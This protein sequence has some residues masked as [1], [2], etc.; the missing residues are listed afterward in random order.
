[1]KTENRGGSG[2]TTNDPVGALKDTKD[3]APLD[4]FKLSHILDLSYFYEES[5]KEKGEILKGAQY[6]G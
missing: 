4:L 1:M 2:L 5:L 3:I 6:V